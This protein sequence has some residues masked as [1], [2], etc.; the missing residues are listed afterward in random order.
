MHAGLINLNG[1]TAEHSHTIG[2]V[3]ARPLPAVGEAPS[4]F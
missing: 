1:E 4:T 3:H 2:C